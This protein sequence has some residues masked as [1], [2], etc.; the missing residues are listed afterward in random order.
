M[1]PEV[2]KQIAPE[3]LVEKER[4]DLTPKDAHLDHLITT[5]DRLTKSIEQNK[6]KEDARSTALGDTID[7]MEKNLRKTNEAIAKRTAAVAPSLG[8]KDILEK[9]RVVCTTLSSA[10][11]LRT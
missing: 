4:L 9:A 10:I 3:S 6:Q 8:I 2:A 5:R 7:G 1:N 11:F